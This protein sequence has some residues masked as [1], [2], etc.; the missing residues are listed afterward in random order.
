LPVARG[1]NNFDGIR[2]EYFRD[3]DVAFAGF[4]SRSYLFREELV[5]RLWATRYDFPAAREG[6]VK[7]DTVPD[8]TASAAQ[9]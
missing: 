4:M 8:H 3:R 7:R 5:S 9:G 1:Q 2:Y 6:Q